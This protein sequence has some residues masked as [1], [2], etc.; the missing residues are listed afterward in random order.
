MGVWD[1]NETFASDQIP[2]RLSRV[3]ILQVTLVRSLRVSVYELLTSL[4]GEPRPKPVDPNSK[5]LSLNYDARHSK[6]VGSIDKIVRPT[7]EGTGYNN[8]AK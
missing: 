3:S 5:R 1:R 6:P 2:L 4:A 7:R 8:P